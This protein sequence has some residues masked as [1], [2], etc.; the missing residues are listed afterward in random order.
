MA[1]VSLIDTSQSAANSLTESTFI[2][3]GNGDDAYGIKADSQ[4]N[5]YIAGLTSSSNFPVTPG[6]LLTTFP[7]GAFGSGFVS[8]L[9]P[10][11]TTL[12]YS[13][14]FGGSGDG[15]DEHVDAG[16]W[17]RPQFLYSN[18]MPILLAKPTRRI[19]RSPGPPWRRCMPD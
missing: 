12:L 17:N 2:G 19:Y 9:N 7:T 14:F 5:A 13:S 15:N 1:F 6:A 3:G 18:R 10:T 8:E 16:I 4:G 11:L